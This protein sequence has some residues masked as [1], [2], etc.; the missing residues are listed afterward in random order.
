[1]KLKE[2]FLPSFLVSESYY[3]MLSDEATLMACVNNTVSEGY[4]KRIEISAMKTQEGMQKLRVLAQKIP[5][6]QWITNDL[7]EQGLNPSTLDGTLRK[8]TID[9]MIR[10]VHVAAQSG[11]DR[12]AFISCAD[13]GP[14]LREEAKKGLAEV[15]CAVCA[16]AEPLGITLLLEPL[17]RG[18]HKNNLIGPTEEAID[19]IQS[20]RRDWKNAA[21]SWDSAHAALNGENLQKAIAQA[22]KYNGQIHLA[23]AVLDRSAEGFGDWHMPMGEP[24]FLTVNTAV[25]LLR[26]AAGEL[27]PGQQLGVTIES[28]SPDRE[29][30]ER[31]V[32][33]NRRFLEQVLEHEV[34]V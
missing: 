12:V 20:V 28:R 19:L 4:Y 31:C 11:A 17:D 5:V 9:E 2:V 26:A 32:A 24:G 7:N 10:L 15:L 34:K 29:S 25:G 33:K 18:A 27:S 23:N 14:V 6:T 1:M 30:M 3:P 13:P 16:A 8:K 22:M 21:L